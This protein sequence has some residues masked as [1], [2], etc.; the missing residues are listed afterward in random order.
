MARA[1]GV[2]VEFLVAVHQVADGH[3]LKLAELS[4][5]RIRHR[6][7]SSQRSG[8]LTPGPCG[9]TEVCMLR[10]FKSIGVRFRQVA[11]LPGGM[12][13]GGA[14]R[15]DGPCEAEREDA[16]DFGVALRGR[17]GLW[18][19]GSHWGLQPTGAARA[20]VVVPYAAVALSARL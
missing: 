13:S 17:H 14:F 16:H 2:A 9:D 1:A 15:M 19:L 7:S 20:P 10:K 11:W 12:R 4:F 3:P 18:V 8:A 6:N 5:D